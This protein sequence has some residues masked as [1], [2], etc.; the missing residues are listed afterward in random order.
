MIFFALNKTQLLMTAILRLVKNMQ[1]LPKTTSI[2]KLGERLDQTMVNQ[3]IFNRR[4]NY[5]VV[6]INRTPITHPNEAKYLGMTLYAR[7][8]LRSYLKAQKE[9]LLMKYGIMY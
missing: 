8:R 4:E 2:A 9:A 6:K 1:K 3:L 7:M 5:V